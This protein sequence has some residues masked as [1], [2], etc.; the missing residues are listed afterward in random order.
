MN[1][2]KETPLRIWAKR[3]DKDCQAMLD[4]L[5]RW[6]RLAGPI[7]VMPD[8][9]KASDVCVGTVLATRDC[10]LP[11]AVGEDLGC[12]MLCHAFD[13]D[14]RQIERP[15]LQRIVDKGMELIPTGRKTHREAQTLPEQLRCRGLS[16]STLEHQKGWLGARHTGTL[17][18]GN[19]FIELQRDTAGRMWLTIHSGSRGI[20]SAIAAHHAK[21]AAALDSERSAPL[22]ALQ[23][24]TPEESAFWNDFD[25][26]VDFAT[27]NRLRMAE[28]IIEVIESELG[29]ALK[30]VERFDVPHNVIRRELQ[31]DGATLV[32]HRKGAMPAQKGMRGIIPGSMGTASYIVEGQGDPQS[33]S[34]CSHGAGRILSRKEARRKFRVSDVERQMKHVVFPKHLA[35]DL[36]E[37]L[38]QAYKDIREVLDLQ[39][40]LA[41]P[42][43]RLEP[44]AVMKGG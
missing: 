44:L 12:G 11:T 19:H 5:A 30:T 1:D 42:V 15:D 9:H 17:G 26:A 39:R 3:M 31:N 16:S 24:G 38:P 27:E 34:S 33:Y 6:G 28:R 22:R 29:I 13:F 20:G 32:I 18:G 4:R 37:E 14:A 40:E 25:W 7:A 2:T 36:V 23:C 10:V 43:L 41:K 8:I 35:A 21:V